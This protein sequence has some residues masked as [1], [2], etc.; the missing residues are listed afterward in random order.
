MSCKKNSYD[1]FNWGKA[2]NKFHKIRLKLNK[3]LKSFALL[4]NQDTHCS[5]SL[6]CSRTSVNQHM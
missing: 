1:S 4:K 2:K 5:D 3:D 6:R